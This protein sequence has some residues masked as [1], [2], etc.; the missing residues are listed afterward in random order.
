MKINQNKASL[1][2]NRMNSCTKKSVIGE[3][4]FQNTNNYTPPE[5]K[6]IIRW[7]MYER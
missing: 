2:A 6:L 3:R 5:R 7:I 4:T 1:I